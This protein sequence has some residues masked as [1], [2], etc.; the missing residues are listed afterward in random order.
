MSL[1]AGLRE[2][3]DLGG[4]DIRG[5]GVKESRVKA[6]GEVEVKGREGRGLGSKSAVPGQLGKVLLC[7][8]DHSQGANS[9]EARGDL[10]AP[11]GRGHGAS[12]PGL[13]G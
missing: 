6:V 10:L 12:G 9:T 8:Q 3:E 4:G 11:R 5:L 13:S 2:G 7:G 1:G